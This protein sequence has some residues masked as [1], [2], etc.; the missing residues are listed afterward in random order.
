M[1]RRTLALGVV[2]LVAVALSNPPTPSG[3]ERQRHREESCT[4]IHNDSQNKED[5]SK[6]RS[7]IIEVRQSEIHNEI[8]S[9]TQPKAKWYSRPDWWVAIFTFLLF[10]STAGLWTFTALMWCSTARLARSSERALADLERPYIFIYEIASQH[11][12][13]VSN[14]PWI[15]Y[16]VANHGKLAAV[17]ETVTIRCGMPDEKGRYPAPIIIADHQLLQSPILSSD[18]IRRNLGYNIPGVALEYGPPRQPKDGMIFQAVVSY[19]G[20]FTRHHETGQCWRFQK[21]AATGFV[22]VIDQRYT[23]AR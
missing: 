22:E 8:R 21:S 16:T 12:G 1:L 23:Y 15:Q 9:Q 13:G 7:F 4:Q 20:P 18:E 3:W 6:C 5:T 19:H 17:I 10:L 2:W 14:P 11:G